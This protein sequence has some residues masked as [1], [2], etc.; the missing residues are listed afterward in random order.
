MTTSVSVA[1]LVLERVRHRIDEALPEIGASAVFDAIGLVFQHRLASQVP[2]KG[3][4][5]VERLVR[6]L[7]T[8]LPRVLVAGWRKYEEFLPFARAPEGSD[9]RSGQVTL[10][11]YE[12]KSQWELAPRLQG[13][14]LG[15]IHLLVGLTLGCDAGTVIVRDARFVG[16][17]AGAIRYEGRLQLKDASKELTKIGPHTIRIPDARLDFGDGW[18]IVPG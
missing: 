18:A 1:D 12:V 7:D 17:E 10:R 14:D 11:Q 3:R 9:E 16:L 5:L 6:A 13:R 15:S 8:P 4:A 2:G